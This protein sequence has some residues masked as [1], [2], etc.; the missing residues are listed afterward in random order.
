MVFYNPNN[1]V[2]YILFGYGEGL[3]RSGGAVL[4]LS[5]YMYES[6]CYVLVL[7]PF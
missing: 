7:Q 6:R 4:L 3:E 2:G 5:G 1:C